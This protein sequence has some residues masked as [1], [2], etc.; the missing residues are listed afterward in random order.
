MR[1]DRHRRRRPRSRGAGASRAIST[2]AALLLGERGGQCRAVLAP[3]V[4][5]PGQI[6][7]RQP[8]VVPALRQRLRRDEV[9]VALLFLGDRGAPGHFRDARGMRALALS[10]RPH[11]EPRL[12][13]FEVRGALQRFIDEAIELRI[14]VGTPPPVPWPGRSRRGEGVRAAE[15]LD[16]FHRRR[17]VHAGKL[18]AAR[19]REEAGAS[20]GLHDERAARGMAEGL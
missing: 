2:W 6:E 17:R 4:E 10:Q 16:L 12:C 14:A 13:E 11:S 7:R 8:I 9:V 19:A 3:E 15:L 20:S 18:C 5:L 1:P